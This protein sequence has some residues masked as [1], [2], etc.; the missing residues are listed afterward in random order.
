MVGRVVSEGIERVT[1]LRLAIL[2]L[3]RSLGL[4]LIDL[5]QEVLPCD[6]EQ[7]SQ[8]RR[9]QFSAG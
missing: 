7:R 2:V 4:L 8:K 6:A 9:K 5:G 1:S 3:R